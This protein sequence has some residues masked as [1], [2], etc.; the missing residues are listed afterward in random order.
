MPEERQANPGSAGYTVLTT[1][2]PKNFDY[3]KSLGA[4]EVFDYND[5]ETAANIK[6]AANHDLKYVW[7]TISL[8]STIKICN[9]AIS[10]GGRY[11]SLLGVS[12]PRD[13]VKSS[14]TLGYTVTG[15]PIV[16]SLMNFKKEDTTEDFNHTVKWNA[17]V[18]KLLA[19]GKLKT[20][21]ITHS[22]KGLD[23]VLEGLELLRNDKVS[24][25]KLVYTL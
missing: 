5:P 3:V 2:S 25:K 15:E 9:E 13:D 20:H 10:S 17:L 4:T 16:K 22:D 12:L 11:A 18:E 19:E 8:E 23:G 6:K 14:S 1:C 24:G 7:D 21:S